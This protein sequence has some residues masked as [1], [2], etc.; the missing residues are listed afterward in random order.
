LLV[1]SPHSGFEWPADFR[2]AAPREAILTTWDAFVDELW[3]AVPDA[4]GTLLV[5]R[6]PRAYADA[7]RAESDLDSSLLGEP[8]PQP[9]APS[10][11]TRRGMGLIR[12]HALPGVP[13]YDR[14]LTVAEVRR[15][16]QA[17]YRPYRETLARRLDA[18]HA[19]FGA[20][21]H[22]NAHSMKS[23]GNAMNLDAGALRPDVVVSDRLGT[24]ADPDLTNELAE[25][26]RQRGFTARVNE[27]YQGGDIVAA[28][29]RPAERRH[30]V[31]IE[32]NR[33]VYMDEAAFERGTG[34]EALRAVLTELAAHLARR[35]VDLAAAG[36]ARV[37]GPGPPVPRALP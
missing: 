24:T 17:Y 25:W 37:N 8:W 20:V 6:F 5:A 23:M 29:G 33:A 4:G 19:R 2:P 7:N 18:L 14:P 3:A 22:V 21:L 10:A 9:L 12:R 28:S 32:L 27:P 11:Y 35:A 34:F 15:R 16:I 36:E 1:D 31:Q 13:M 30:S 26:F